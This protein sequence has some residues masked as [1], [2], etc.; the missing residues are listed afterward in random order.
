MNSVRILLSLVANKECALHQF[1]IKNAVLHGD[2]EDKVYM[3]IFL[4]FDDNKLAEKVCKLKKLL[5]GLKQ[6][7]IKW[8][9]RFTHAMLKWGFKQNQGDHTLFNKHSSQEKITTLI[10]YVDDIVVTGDDLEKII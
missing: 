2:L 9:E 4:G 5:Y 6:S 1:D 7:S 3:N 8:F 10:V